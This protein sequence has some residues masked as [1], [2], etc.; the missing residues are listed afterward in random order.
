MKSSIYSK[1]IV[2]G[3]YG[4]YRA[5]GV[6]WVKKIL[7]CNIPMKANTE[8][9]VYES[10]DMSIPVSDTPV[11]Y[12]VNAFF[13]KTLK[14]DD[15]VKAVLLVKKDEL[16]NYKKNVSECIEELMTVA[17]VSGAKIEYKIIDTDFSESQ[18][19]HDKLL[20]DIV[21]EFEDEA[22]ITADI[23]YGPKD[24]PI[25]LFTALNFGEKF[26]NCNI[27]NIVYGQ[28]TFV[29]GKPANTKICDMIPLYYLNSITNTVQCDS[30]EKAK[31]MLKSLLTIW[32]AEDEQK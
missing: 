18:S 7:F 22:C 10:E 28:A 13:E 24:L 29:D 16:G 27:E 21:E 8:K 12:P 20:L 9:C 4:S 30:S 15:E 32:G 26:F 25:V 31:Q 3:I 2:Q 5:E 14:S 23:T 1:A 19:I 6:V 17:S 11:K